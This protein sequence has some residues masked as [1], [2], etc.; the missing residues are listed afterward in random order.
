MFVTSQTPSLLMKVHNKN[1]LELKS[2]TKKSRTMD[3]MTYI[4]VGIINCEC[5]EWHIK[6]LGFVDCNNEVANKEWILEV[7]VHLYNNGCCVR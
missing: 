2:S 4:A 6:R 5:E 3:I 7:S 1:S